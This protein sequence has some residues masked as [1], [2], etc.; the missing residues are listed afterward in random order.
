M[1]IHYIS[2]GPYAINICFSTSN[3]ALAV[4]LE[5]SDTSACFLLFYHVFFQRVKIA[6]KSSDDDIFFFC[7]HKKEAVFAFVL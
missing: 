7:R 4:N 1:Y 3:L 6:T 2:L 5:K